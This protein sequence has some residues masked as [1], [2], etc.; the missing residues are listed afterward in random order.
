MDNTWLTTHKCGPNTGFTRERCRC[1]YLQSADLET[2]VDR[3]PYIALVCSAHDRRSIVEIYLEQLSWPLRGDSCLTTNERMID[4]FTRHSHRPAHIH[5][6]YCDV[7]GWR[8][9]RTKT[10][11]H[12]SPY[13]LPNLFYVRLRYLHSCKTPLCR[14]T[15]LL[16]SAVT[17]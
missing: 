12:S 14:S 5:I 3:S 2:V 6:Q 11:H 10:R 15:V 7:N 4:S 8:R 9:W 16:P 13:W 1:C 17:A